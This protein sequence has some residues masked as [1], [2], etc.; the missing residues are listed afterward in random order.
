MNLPLMGVGLVALVAIAGAGVQTVRLAN[1]AADL[2]GEKAAFADFKKDLA[3][4]TL[5]VTREAADRSDRAIDVLN[6]TLEAVSMVGAQAKTEIRY[7]QSSGGPCAADPVYR[8][9]VDG[10][11]ATLAARG[12]GGGQGPAGS[13][14]PAAMRRADPARPGKVAQ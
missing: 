1:T 7:V 13:G 8:A 9:T 6:R 5:R 10:V 14:A 2:A 11:R 12:P 4:E 3:T